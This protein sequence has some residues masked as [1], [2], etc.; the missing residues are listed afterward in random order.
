[1]S[2]LDLRLNSEIKCELFI[3]LAF[4]AMQNCKDYLFLDHSSRIV[5][6]YDIV[7]WY[8]ILLEIARLM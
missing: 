7:L 5:I 3:Q 4:S 6:D 8:Y 1:M 2:S